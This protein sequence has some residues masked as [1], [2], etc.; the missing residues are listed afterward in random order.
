MQIQMKVPFFKLAVSLEHSG[1]KQTPRKPTQISVDLIQNFRFK[2][3]TAWLV[4][5]SLAQKEKTYYIHFL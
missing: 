4:L 5:W 3:D 1:K 2:F